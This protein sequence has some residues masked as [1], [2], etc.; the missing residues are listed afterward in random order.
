MTMRMSSRQISDQAAGVGSDHSPPPQPAA[1][2]A[3][4]TIKAELVLAMLL[5]SRHRTPRLVSFLALILIALFVWQDFARAD[6]L[7]GFEVGML[8]VTTLAVVGCSRL[9][10]LGGALESNRVVAAP[11]WVVPAG[12]LLGAMILLAPMTLIIGAALVLGRGNNPSLA[13]FFGLTILLAASLGALTLSITPIFGASSAASVGFALAFFG[14]VAPSSISLM[15]DKFP[16]IRNAVVLLWN[17][18]PLPWRAMSWLA[19][20]ERFF[21]VLAFSWIV[22]GVAASSWTLSLRYRV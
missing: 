5:I 7:N 4:H 14:A 6:T 1:Q 3:L 8:L 11:W 21:G 9:A 15:L 2:V 10:S 20:D 16:P 17:L 13:S 18:L 22:L 19:G 12:R